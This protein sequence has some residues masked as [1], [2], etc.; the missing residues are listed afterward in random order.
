[1][2]TQNADVP[3]AQRMGEWA[4]LYFKALTMIANYPY[5]AVNGSFSQ[6]EIARAA[7]NGGRDPQ[8]GT[9]LLGGDRPE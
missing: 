9:T 7:L 1:M 5:P 2:T 3:E 8:S 6:Q 4:A